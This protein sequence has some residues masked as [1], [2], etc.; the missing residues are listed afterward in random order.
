MNTA[1]LAFA[2]L[3]ALVVG[4][5]LGWLAGAARARASLQERLV[6][7][8]TT[9]R[10]LQD[11]SETLE[12]DAQVAGELTA[13]VGPLSADLRT[14]SQ[15]VSGQD[16]QQ[17]ARLA[18]LDEQLRQLALQNERL[19][20]SAA[21]LHSAL[22]AT[23]ARGDWGEVQLRRIVELAGM[24]E[25]VDFDVQVSVRTDA[26]AGRPDMVV[27]L[28]GEASI[29][30]DAKAPLSGLDPERSGE[31]AQA[32]AVRRHV[33]ALSKKAYWQSFSPAPR[34]VVCF[35]PSDGLLAAAGQEDP[36]LIDDALTAG[37]ILA[38]PSTLLGL[39]KTVALN[40]Q[41]VDLSRSAHRIL[42]LGRE[43]HARVSTLTEHLVRMGTSLDR[44][45][46]DYNRLIGSFESRFLP[47][48]RKLSATGVAEADLPEPQ[49]LPSRSRGLTAAEF[50]AEAQEVMG[51]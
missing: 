2:L 24:L 14:L 39:L 35:L 11:R 13:A 23:S 19:R 9:A 42:D 21:E 45:V 20:I 5:A 44:T 28:P 4:L 46:E 25:H 3:L 50:A 22:S 15:H 32:R 16:R 6:R 43:L 40:W 37:V 1:L 47:T 30:I 10:L 48:A 17:A 27:R 12:A 18:G 29:V 49:E 41:Q 51:S 26:G 8:E 34:F 33:S 31:G 38:S 7:A 36:A